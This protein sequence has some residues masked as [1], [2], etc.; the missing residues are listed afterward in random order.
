MGLPAGWVTD[1]G[2]PSNAQLKALGNGIVPQQMALAIRLL[3]DMD[4]TAVAHDDQLIGT[5][6]AGLGT[7]GGRRSHTFDPDSTS[8]RHPN[9]RELIDLLG[10]NA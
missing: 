10:G 6:T 2:I 3:L 1:V 9:P 5:P 7:G 8:R 4:A